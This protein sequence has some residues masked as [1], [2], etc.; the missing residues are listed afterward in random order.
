MNQCLKNI[1]TPAFVEMLDTYKAHSIM[2]YLRTAA[3]FLQ[4]CVDNPLTGADAE[5]TCPKAR[6]AINF[7]KALRGP[8]D[9]PPLRMA[10]TLQTTWSHLI[11]FFKFVYKINLI[12][13][14]AVGQ[15]IITQCSKA[16]PPSKQ[17]RAFTAEQLEQLYA[18]P[19]WGEH[20][21][22]LVPQAILA[23]HGG[24]RSCETSDTQFENIEEL[25]DR[26]GVSTFHVKYT[27]QKEITADKNTEVEFYITAPTEVAV[28][29][30][31]IAMTP[32]D[33]RTLSLHY[34]TLLRYDIIKSV[35][36]SEM[37]V[38]KVSFVPKPS[39]RRFRNALD[40]LAS[41]SGQSRLRLGRPVSGISKTAHFVP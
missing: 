24:E 20:T 8:D 37:P 25:T 5:D 4:F 9:Q 10:S 17:A 38:Y 39:I 34:Y 28:I 29:R 13:A 27:R 26:S 33:T 6:F 21:A 31:Y 15:R 11:F 14:G 3:E 41:G 36:F 23:T 1:K 40:H 2:N 30:N 7:I 22:H 32:A 35:S 18:E 16:D 12:D 19:I